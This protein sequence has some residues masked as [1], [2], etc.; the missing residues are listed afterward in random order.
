MPI[1][2]DVEAD[3][4]GLQRH[5]KGAGSNVELEQDMGGTEYGRSTND[6]D[7]Q[8]LGFQIP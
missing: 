7:I 8:T 5:W 6:D 1:E 2:L 4:G 3:R